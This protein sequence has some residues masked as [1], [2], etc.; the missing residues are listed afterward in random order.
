MSFNS[1]PR[2]RDRANAVDSR[3]LI[4]LY[5]CEAA[6]VVTALAVKRYYNLLG[7]LTA[8][9]AAMLAAPI[10]V[11]LASGVYLGIRLMRGLVADRR[12]LMFAIALNVLALL[13]ALAGGEVLVRAFSRTD[14]TG[15]Q[16]GGTVLLPKDW[17]DVKAR[18]RELL[19]LVR[20]DLSYFVVDDRLGW[21]PGRSRKS[22]EGMYSTSTEGFR[23][24]DAGDSYASRPPGPR[25]AIVGD[26]FTF[27]V[28]VPFESSWG[29]VLE[30]S[31]GAPTTV[32]N[33]GVDG[34]GVDQAVLRYERDARAWKPDVAILGFINHDLE[35]S[36]SVYPFVTFPEWGL[37]FTKPRYVMDKGEL[38]LL[39]DP[40][41][42]P[43]QLFSAPSIADLPFI[44]HDSG[45]DPDEWEHHPYDASYA[46]RFLRSRFRRWPALTGNPNGAEMEQL[47]AALISRFIRMTMADGTVP[48]V[49]YLPARADFSEGGSVYRDA[50]LRTLNRAGV[51]YIDLKACVAAVG[52]SDAFVPG[53]PHYS[54]AG[55]AAVARCLLPVVRHALAGD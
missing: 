14:T 48:L 45:W 50:T 5:V 8:Q 2:Q 23:S 31:L 36:L 53:R 11:A 20:D 9:Q 55:N 3:L 1:N 41:E 42:S 30:G 29:A 47:N 40:L 52:V 27:G 49:V 13:L 46:V 17:D 25:I 33:L 38:K 6:A 24:A 22:R 21:V 15:T 44:A 12:S 26:S 39:A 4:A 10:L 35:R 54:P 34:Y 32:L 7:T 19:A 37:P 16:F 28:E 51:E 18:H 43:Q